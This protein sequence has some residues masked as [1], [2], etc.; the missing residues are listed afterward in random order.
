M[1]DLAVSLRESPDTLS[2]RHHGQTAARRP[3]VR[4]LAGV[5]EDAVVLVLAVLLLPVAIYLVGIP[6]ALC[7]QAITAIVRLVI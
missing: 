2:V 1:P 3:Y 4:K 5:L 6:I 7:V